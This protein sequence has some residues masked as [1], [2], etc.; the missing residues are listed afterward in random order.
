[1]KEIIKYQAEDGTIFDTEEDC[2]EYE[3]LC[4]ALSL[5]GKV[6]FYYKNNLEMIK[7]SLRARLESCYYFV[8]IDNS[9][10]DSLSYKFDDY[11]ILNPWRQMKNTLPKKI[12]V[13]WYNEKEDMWEE[14][15]SVLKETIKKAKSFGIDVKEYL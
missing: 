5:R 2:F 15:T 8:V 12:G 4:F 3:D 14:Y 1:M 13:Y 6:K 10:I 11:G 9:V 7:E